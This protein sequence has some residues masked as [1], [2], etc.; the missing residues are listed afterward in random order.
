ML[1]Q[2]YLVNAPNQQE[3]LPYCIFICRTY[4]RQHT[5][6]KL[7]FSSRTL[8]KNS[9]KIM[10]VCVCVSAESVSWNASICNTWQTFISAFTV[11]W[12]SCSHFFFFLQ[13]GSEL[14]PLVIFEIFLR[15]TLCCLAHKCPSIDAILPHPCFECVHSLHRATINSPPQWQ[16]LSVKGNFWFLLDGFVLV[17]L[18]FLLKQS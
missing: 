3:E 6:F 18:W 5:F 15:S 16:L 14:T 9:W 13:T 10:R 4:D 2:S 11:R 17:I 1:R 8:A 12:L 7:G